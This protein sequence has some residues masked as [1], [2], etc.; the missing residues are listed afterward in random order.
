MEGSHIGAA[1]A[2]AS[3]TSRRPLAMG[4]AALPGLRRLLDDTRNARYGGSEEAPIASLCAHRVCD[5]GVA[6]AARVLGVK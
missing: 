1:S 4:K 6:L 5:L 2:S 3:A